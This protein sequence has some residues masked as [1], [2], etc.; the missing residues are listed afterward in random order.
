MRSR[1]GFTLVELMVVVVII[2]ILASFAL[3]Q[4]QKAVRKAH[5]RD[6]V[7]QLTSLHAAN[8]MYEAKQDAYLAGNPLNLA[9]INSGLNLNI[10]ANDMTYSYTSTVATA[11][12]ATA[13]WTD[14]TVRVNQTPIA[15]GTNPCCSAGTCPTLPAC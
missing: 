11:Y 12:T 2:G 8:I 6:A 5:E 1:T 14:F 10:I 15:A 7:I 9:Q 4:Y 13:A 3:P